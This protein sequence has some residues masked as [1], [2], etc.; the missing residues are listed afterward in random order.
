MAAASASVRKQDQA[1]CVARQHKIGRKLDISSGYLNAFALHGELSFL[2]VAV[3]YRAHGLPANDTERREPVQPCKSSK[4]SSALFRLPGTD[5]AQSR[6]VIP[7]EHGA[8][9]G[10]FMGSLWSRACT[11]EWRRGVA[12]FTFHSRTG[13]KPGGFWRESYPLTV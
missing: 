7:G 2:R 5:F 1:C 13:S 11:G 10:E 9:N 12:W 6:A 8:G 4:D 3:L